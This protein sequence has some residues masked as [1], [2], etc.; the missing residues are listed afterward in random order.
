[1]SGQRALATFAAVRRC[2]FTGL[3]ERR[4][5]GDRCPAHGRR[6]CAAGYGRAWIAAGYVGLASLLASTQA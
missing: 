5:K 2:R 4:G 6:E 1:M 3:P